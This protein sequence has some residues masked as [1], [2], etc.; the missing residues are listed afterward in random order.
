MIFSPEKLQELILS[1]ILEAGAAAAGA[2]A[3]HSLQE[4]PAVAAWFGEGRHAGM[5]YL[6]DHRAL[7]TDPGHVLP[8]VRS[9]VCAAFAHPVC[10]PAAGVPAIAGYALGE[11]YHVRVRRALQ[12]VAEKLNEWIPCQTRICVDSA[13]LPERYW[14][15]QAGVGFIGTNGCLIVPGVGPNVVLGELLTDAEIAPTEPMRRRCVQCNRCIRDCP[16]GALSAAGGLDARLCLSYWTTQAK[17]EPPAFIRERMGGRFWGCETCVSICPHVH[18]SWLQ[19]FSTETRSLLNQDEF[20]KQEPWKRSVFGD[21][22]AWRLRRNLS[23]ARSSRPPENL[24]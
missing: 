14:A 4:P 22:P 23:L 7:K 19:D 2:A 5:R 16:T 18:P 3:A 15:V 12:K 17:E 6:E 20:W 13:P 24:E 9:I 21:G 8:G 1:E 11:D 10:P